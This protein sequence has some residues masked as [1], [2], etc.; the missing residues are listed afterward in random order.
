MTFNKPIQELI[1]M[2]ISCRTFNSVIIPNSIYTQLNEA[3]Q[4]LNQK[5]S[6][7]VRFLLLNRRNDENNSTIKLGTYGLLAG[8]QVFI[9]AV[10][11]AQAGNPVELGYLFEKAILTATD[12]G[13]STCWL[14]GTFNRGDFEKNIELGEHEY[15]PIVSP[16]GY[17]K[18]HRSLMDSSLRFGAG[19]NARK[20]WTELFFAD[21]QKTPLTYDN[22]GLYNTALEMVRLGP[23]ASNKQPW[24]ILKMNNKFHFFIQR[25]PGY[26]E[27]LK[28]DIQLNDLG[29][30]KC[31]FELTVL[32]LGYRG[33]WH[34]LETKP[35]LKD[36]D[37]CFSWIAE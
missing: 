9:V 33:A 8:V 35:N 20:A 37:Y 22:A 24:R 31:H 14:G 7:K 15:I 16:I 4:L 12:L 23:S 2:R 5:A 26:G 28:Y 3:L 17:A 6:S 32:D 30:A 27:K 10:I 11:N 36:C 1:Q 29:I 13:L 19:S 25:N 21:D 18:D 34:T